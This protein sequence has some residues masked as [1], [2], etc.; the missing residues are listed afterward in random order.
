MATSFIPTL[1]LPMHNRNM[2]MEFLTELAALC[3]N[4]TFD[5]T[6]VVWKCGL[7]Y[8]SVYINEVM[9]YKLMVECVNGVMEDSFRRAKARLLM[10]GSQER[11]LFVPWT[12]YP[13]A[14]SDETYLQ[15]LDEFFNK[16]TAMCVPEWI[17]KLGRL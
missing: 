11:H 15:E 4:R 16:W 5:D 1:V 6:S 12:D 7:T 9:T 13:I 2:T 14:S 17:D 8:L 3:D 10:A